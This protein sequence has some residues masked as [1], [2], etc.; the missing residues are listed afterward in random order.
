MAITF[1]AFNT[2]MAETRK[3]AGLPPLKS[4]DKTWQA[5]FKA[6]NAKLKLL[7]TTA[8]PPA[9]VESPDGAET[10]PG[11]PA[12]IV[13]GL[14]FRIDATSTPTGQVFIGSTVSQDSKNVKRLRRVGDAVLQFA[15]WG[16]GEAEKGWFTVHADGSKGVAVADPTAPVPT[17]PPPTP[18]PPP[19]PTGDPDAFIAP[20]ISIGDLFASAPGTYGVPITLAKPVKHTIY[21]EL[22]TRNGQG[23]YA[24]H[25]YQNQRGIVVFQPGDT[26][27]LW[28]LKIDQPLTTGQTIEVYSTGFHGGSF[29]FA[30]FGFLVGEGNVAKDKG[31]VGN[32]STYPKAAPAP[33]NV[34]L[35]YPRPANVKM[36][37]RFGADFFA[38][39]TG[40]LNGRTGWL[41]RLPHGREQGNNGEPGYY[42]SKALNGV[43]PYVRTPGGIF[44]QAQAVPGGVKENGQQKY[45]M[46]NGQPQPYNHAAGMINAERI[47]PVLPGDYVEATLSLPE[48]GWP[49][50]WLSPIDHWL[51][52][53]GEYDIL[54]GFFRGGY[55]PYRVESSQHWK[56]PNNEHRAF[57]L[58]GGIKE[59]AIPGLDLR[60]KHKWG[61]HLGEKLTYLID[62]VPYMQMPNMGSNIAR[63]LM[64]NVTLEAG[65]TDNA[66]LPAKMFVESVRVL[67]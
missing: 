11:G 39:D 10:T 59:A 21:I 29:G 57:G 18:V 22:S 42:V 8:P 41:D 15:V 27:K 60:A 51:W 4:T 13:K 34:Q 36:D 20:V 43:D 38:N 24:P 25:H 7:L 61:C 67:R 56:G 49:A 62:D 32:V 55:D 14:A 19:P 26:C 17:T 45:F 47:C 31:F 1:A 40:E 3:L 37:E 23:A 9:P 33:T 66:R 65:Q 50:F 52:P 35:A 44:I 2:L 12:L 30:S 46:Q 53:D 64:L 6:T 48:Y 58:K 54:E 63:A 5:D 16:E 28:P